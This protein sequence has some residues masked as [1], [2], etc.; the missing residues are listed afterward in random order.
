MHAIVVIAVVKS[1]QVIWLWLFGK[2][3]LQRQTILVRRRMVVAKTY[4]LHSIE[5]LRK[6]LHIAETLDISEPVWQNTCKP[7]GNFDLTYLFNTTRNLMLTFWFLQQLSVLCQTIPNRTYSVFNFLISFIK[8]V[9]SRP[10]TEVFEV[11]RIYFESNV[12]C[13]YPCTL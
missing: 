11:F 7:Y 5:N 12:S 10:Y 3:L 4:R 6:W 13:L 9:I 8:R 2:L 1:L